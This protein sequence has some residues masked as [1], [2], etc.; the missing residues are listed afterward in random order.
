[1][2]S[3]V[4]RLPVGHVRSRSL[5]KARTAPVAS[6]APTWFTALTPSAMTFVS[7]N[8]IADTG[9]TDPD[10]ALAWNGAAVEQSRREFCMGCSGGHADYDGNEMLVLRLGQNTPAW[11]RTRAP[12][13]TGGT[14]S[15]NGAGVHSNSQPLGT[16]TYAL[17]AAGNGRFW[18]PGLG[19]QSGGGTWTTTCFSYDLTQ[20]SSGVWNRHGRIWTSTPGMNWL[21]ASCAWDPVDNAI[22]VIGQYGDDNRV[23]KIDCAAAVS[24]GNVDHPTAMGNITRYG[25]LLNPGIGYMTV[26]HDLRLLIHVSQNYGIA[27]LDLTNPGG[28]W[29]NP[30][31]VTGTGITP[32]PGHAVWH[33]PSR[34]ML[35]WSNTGSTVRKCVVPA[36]PATGTWAWSNVTMGGSAWPNHALPSGTNGP[37]SK[38]NLVEDMGNGESCLVYVR[39]VT[40]AGFYACRLTGAI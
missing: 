3:L 8:S 26:A 5:A 39:D 13:G 1:M 6:S 20:E 12:A 22:W 38:F 31:A 23:C 11:V 18:L 40:E 32:Y 7:S 15:E 29:A 9:S 25:S 34:A 37:F 27:F 36:N 4:P 14:D 35:G 24:A 10:I 28:G 21:G 33:A 19:A 16:H 30:T 17:Q 2:L